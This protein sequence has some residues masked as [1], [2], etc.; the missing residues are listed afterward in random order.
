MCNLFDEFGWCCGCL[1][2]S[3]PCS[4]K[5]WIGV[6]LGVPTKEANQ[7]QWTLKWWVWGFFCQLFII[8]LLGLLAIGASRRKIKGS[9]HG[10]LVHDVVVTSH[11]SLR[12]YG[13]P[14]TQRRTISPKRFCYRQVVNNFC[15]EG[16]ICQKNITEVWTL[17]RKRF[18]DY[19]R[20]RPNRV[21]TTWYSVLDTRP[22][23]GTPKPLRPGGSGISASLLYC[24]AY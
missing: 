16:H 7:V 24:A 5:N 15:V 23:E 4:P 8:R 13:N 19:G 6:L 1:Y 12:S 11:N 9:G 14:E 3:H 22:V 10:F 20:N 2:S 21:R 18:R 17:Y